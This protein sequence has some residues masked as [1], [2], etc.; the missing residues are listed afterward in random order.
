MSTFPM[1]ASN[2]ITKGYYFALVDQINNG[3]CSLQVSK[4]LMINGNYSYHLISV[5]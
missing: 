1:S 4:R 2:Q 3:T 5:R